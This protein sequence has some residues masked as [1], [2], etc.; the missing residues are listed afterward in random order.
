MPLFMRKE[1]FIFPF[2]W[3]K[4]KWQI[5]VSYLFEV[6]C[7]ATLTWIEKLIKFKAPK[8]LPMV[9]VI[10][11]DYPLLSKASFFDVS[12]KIHSIKGPD[13]IPVKTCGFGRE[14]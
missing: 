8:L 4:P 10:A 11:I 13:S 6:L 3:F 5:E 14:E 1:K 7:G 9:I 2:P 12:S